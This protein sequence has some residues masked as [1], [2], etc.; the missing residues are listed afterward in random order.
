MYPTLISFGPIQ[1][2]TL[3][4][5][6]VIGMVL[7]A[8]M[9]W[10]RAHEE[11]YDDDETFD[12]MLIATLVGWLAARVFHILFYYPEFGLDPWTWISLSTHPGLHEMSGIIVGLYMV[13]WLANRR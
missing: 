13:W 10:R 7:A 5:L 2:S 12:V 4:F 8:F 3:S 6:A 11:H 1:I 9:I